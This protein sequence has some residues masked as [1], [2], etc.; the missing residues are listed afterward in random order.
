MD[1]LSLGPFE[2]HLLERRVAAG[3]S[4]RGFVFVTGMYGFPED[5]MK[6]ESTHCHVEGEQRVETRGCTPEQP[7]LLAARLV[8]KRE[9]GGT[10]AWGQRRAA[11]GD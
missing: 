7:R 11:R 9:R 4:S 6:L 5:V 8:R 2:A 10:Q 3:G 1:D